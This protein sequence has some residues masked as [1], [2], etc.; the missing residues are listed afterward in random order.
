MLFREPEGNSVTETEILLAIDTLGTRMEELV[1]AHPQF[2]FQ[3][4]ADP[5]V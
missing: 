5:R 3:D 1:D 4:W 2:W